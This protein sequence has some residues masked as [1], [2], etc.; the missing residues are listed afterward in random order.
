MLFQV[1]FDVSVP[2]KPEHFVD[3]AS[4]LWQRGTYLFIF[5]WDNEKANSNGQAAD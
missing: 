3:T 5:G 4:T 1:I 2:L